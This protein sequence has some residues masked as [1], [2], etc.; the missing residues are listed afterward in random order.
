MYQDLIIFFL[1]NNLMKS[2]KLC[3][4]IQ[5]CYYY[6]GDYKLKNKYTWLTKQ[7]IILLFIYVIL[8]FVINVNYTLFLLAQW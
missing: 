6:N 1:Y 2:Y 4:F 7:V 3:I 8:I 5:Y